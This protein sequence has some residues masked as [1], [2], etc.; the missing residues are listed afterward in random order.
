MYTDDKAVGA[1]LKRCQ[2]LYG[3]WGNAETETMLKRLYENKK[4]LYTT[5]K[6]EHKPSQD[7]GHWNVD[8][9]ENKFRKGEVL[10]PDMPLSKRFISLTIKQV[11]EAIS[12]HHPAL[13]QA[14]EALVQHVEDT[15]NSIEGCVPVSL[16]LSTMYDLADLDDPAHC[17]LQLQ[18]DFITLI[19]SY[20]LAT[21]FQGSMPN[22]LHQLDT[23]LW[24]EGHCPLCGQQ[25]HWGM[26]R[27]P[28][29]AKVMQCWLC[30]TQW[31]FPRLQ[32]PS[33]ATTEQQDL[34]YFTLE[35]N[36]ACRVDVCH[37]CKAYYKLFN[38]RTIGDEQTCLSLHHLA[39]L[40]WDYWA[41]KEGFKA[42]SKLQWVSM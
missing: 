17:G 36:V 22:A 4:V 23:T 3:S 39:T 1:T 16:L 34:A 24:A 37:K 25:P 10:L 7:E 38:M 14:M 26:L 9:I 40:N 5:F 21:V 8:F 6:E 27:D 18:R 13:Q 29:G 35:D 2:Q 42:G 20:V 12:R 19:M 11:D 15:L 31:V 41:R 28:D 30:S 32:C 33:C